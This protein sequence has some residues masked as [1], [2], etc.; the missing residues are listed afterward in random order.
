[1]GSGVKT[2]SLFTSRGCL[3]GGCCCPNSQIEFEGQ[4][5]PCGIGNTS[6]FAMCL[7]ILLGK[8]ESTFLKTDNKKIHDAQKL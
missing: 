7:F 6:F 1:M 8:P 2:V 4:G 5:R 3:G